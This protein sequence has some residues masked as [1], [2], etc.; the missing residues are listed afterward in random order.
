MSFDLKINKIIIISRTIIEYYEQAFMLEQDNK[1]DTAE[2]KKVIEKIKDFIEYEE[3]LLSELT[4][5]ERSLSIEWLSKKVTN[6]SKDI[7][8]SID[9]I[10]SDDK[11]LLA[12][13]RLISKLKSK[14]LE[15]LGE[16]LKNVN[17]ED[18]E[19]DSEEELNNLK[20]CV[21]GTS[22]LYL[23]LKD[24]E[25]ILLAFLLEK[26]ITDESDLNTKKGL[27]KIKYQLIATYPSLEKRFIEGK[28]NKD[29]TIYFNT[30]LV[31][32]FFRLSQGILE[33]VKIDYSNQIYVNSIERLLSIN[34][35]DFD[36]RKLEIQLRELFIR[37]AFQLLDDDLINE[38]HTKFLSVTENN[39]ILI[40]FEKGIE[41]I[42]HAFKQYKSDRTLIKKVT[43]G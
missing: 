16:P 19:C 17:P 36:N 26:Q 39:E 9:I 28:L 20:R 13:Q 6:L 1:K 25:I 5:D 30:D 15:N 42:E 43:L 3:R 34:N 23:T 11:E 21:E 27:I 29:E 22:L 7:F 33:Y 14:H 12:Y 2:Y 40:G 8:D 31:S 24:D 37:A 38:V 10:L 4:P 35:D 18:Y 41:A 32:T